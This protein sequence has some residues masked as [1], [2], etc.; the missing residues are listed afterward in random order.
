MKSETFIGILAIL[1]INLGVIIIS[2]T[3]KNGGW[4]STPTAM[5]HQHPRNILLPGSLPRR[6]RHH[7]RHLHA[8]A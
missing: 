6:M 1:T 4:F 2:F 5:R 3:N 8:N 7:Q